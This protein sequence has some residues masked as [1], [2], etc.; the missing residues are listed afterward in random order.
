ME[1]RFH[2]SVPA[3]NDDLSWLRSV[4]AEETAG[5]TVST[6]ASN[7]DAIPAK[8]STIVLATTGGSGGNE[9]AE[10]AISY[11]PYGL[12]RVLVIEGAGM[13]RW[14]F[15]PDRRGTGQDPYDV[16]WR[17]TL[18]WL[19]SNVTLLPGHRW[20]LR[21]DKTVFTTSELAGVTL[22][23]RDDLADQPAPAITLKKVDDEEREQHF[24]PSPIS[25][26]PGTFRAS[27]GPLSE[28]EYRVRI[29]D[30]TSPEETDQAVF[31]VRPLIEEQLD[32]VA[33]GEFMA[34]LAQEAGG[35]P[36]DDASPGEI[37]R[38]F[39]EHRRRLNPPLLARTTAWDR[40]WVMAATLALWMLTWGIRRRG[41]LV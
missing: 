17:N 26:A 5:A 14:A 24:T 6:L 36:L 38:R 40:W 25:G 12:G 7:A 20:A 2:M 35:V 4:L 18:R 9:Q 23:V 19:V 29:G 34:R 27:F 3:G 39:E 8:P 22:V 11:L 37:V 10:P 16:L 41:G 15:L 13:W 1:S 31:E 32:L 33:R 21:A 30:T 28:G